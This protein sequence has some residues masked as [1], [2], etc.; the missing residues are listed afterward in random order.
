MASGSPES[1]VPGPE[2][3]WKTEPE[4]RFREINTQ[5][6]GEPVSEGRRTKLAPAKASACSCYANQATTK[7]SY[8]Q[9]TQ[10]QPMQSDAQ[11]FSR[12]RLSLRLMAA[13]EIIR[14]REHPLL[15][16]EG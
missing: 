16:L 13:V 4:R 5:T 10:L 15:L 12:V 3:F 8:R 9:D 14:K 11:L 6:L 7:V 2:S 1:S